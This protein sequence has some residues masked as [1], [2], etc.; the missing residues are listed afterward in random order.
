MLS[1]NCVCKTE[2]NLFNYFLLKYQ[3][4]TKEYKDW[5]S[6]RE[7]KIIEEEDKTIFNEIVKCIDNECYRAAYLLCW[8]SLIE[9]LKRKISKYSSLGD[10]NAESAVLEIEATEKKK[11]STD[12]LIFELANKCGIIDE[13]DITTVQF[14]WDQRCLFAHPYEK[15]PDRE[16]VNYILDQSIKI[17]LGRDLFLNKTY[18]ED[19]CNNITEKPFFLPTDRVH[20]TEYAKKII[21]RTPQNLFPFFFKTLLFKIGRIKDDETK[22]FEQIKLRNFIIEV[23]LKSEIDL[24]SEE[25]G[26]EQRATNY[27]YESFL[28]YVNPQIWVKLPIRIKDILISYMEYE[29]NISRLNILQTITSKLIRD[30]VLESN[31]LSRFY[32]KLNDQKFEYAI[33]YYGDNKVAFKRIKEILETNNYE[34][35]N[36]VIDFLERETSVS[37]INGLDIDKQFLLGRLIIS[38]YLNNNWKSRYLIN[39]LLKDNLKY[40]DFVKAGVSL[41]YVLSISNFFRIDYSNFKISLDI[42]NSLMPDAY[43]KVFQQLDAYLDAK[44]ADEMDKLTFNEEQFSSEILK[45]MTNIEWKSDEVK[46]RAEVFILKLKSY[47]V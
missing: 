30:E 16:E 41:G 37:M 3:T 40:S 11:N 17:S 13:S 19:L 35:Q 28:G 8:I 23:L 25:W 1:N 14:F 44:P 15:K 39:N 45:I 38:A 10:K 36:P 46:S 18:I 31:Y 6:I 47:F 24:D 22:T 20:V 29:Q 42:V 12:K 9:S 33:N 4:M 26:L 5:I 21:S 43:N 34:S 27:P 2:F 32:K 7:N